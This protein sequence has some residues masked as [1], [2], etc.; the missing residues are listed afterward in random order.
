MNLKFCPIFSLCLFVSLI[1]SVFFFSFPLSHISWPSLTFITTTPSHLSPLY[2]SLST[3]CFSNQ[4]STYLPLPMPAHP[5]S[6]QGTV[7]R[8]T[9]IFLFGL[10]ADHRHI[11]SLSYT[12]LS[13]RIL[14]IHV[15]TILLVLISRK[16][17]VIFFL[18]VIV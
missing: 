15:S 7:V 3:S 2:L 16:T 9:M 1:L 12:C 17:P 10:I 8:P 14:S 18:F 4:S 11:L 13:Q 5:L 6:F